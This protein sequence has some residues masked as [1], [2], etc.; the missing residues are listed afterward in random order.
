[1]EHTSPLPLDETLEAITAQVWDAVRHLPRLRDHLYNDDDS[2]PVF[3]AAT[4]EDVVRFREHAVPGLERPVEEAVTEAQDIF[5]F[6][7]HVNHPRF[8]S[9]IPS[10]ASPLSWLGDLLTSAF[11]TYSGVWQGGPGITTVEVTLVAWLAAQVGLPPSASGLF[12]SGG[13]MANLTAMA[14]ARDQRLRDDERTRG[15]AYFSDQTHF[16]VPKVLRIL[17]LFDGQMRTIPSDAKFRIDMVELEKAIITDKDQ[18][19]I[20]FLIVANCGTTNTGAI[21][22]LNEIADLAH[23]HGMWM[24]VDGAYGASVALSNSYRS[25]LSGLERADSLAWDAHKWLFQTFGCAIVLVRD[26]VHLA[27]SFTTSA[28]YLRDITT[29]DDTPNLFNYGI[30]LTRPARHMRLWFSLRVLGLDTFGRMIDHGFMLAATA[31]AELRKLPGW[32]ITSPATLSIVT[33]RYCPEGMA[34]DAADQFNAAI[35]SNAMQSNIAFIYTTRLRGRV[36]LRIC[37]INPQTS[38][39]DMQQIIKE[40]HNIACKHILEQ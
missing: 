15:V 33:F 32:K 26:K 31:E 1:M 30:E 21:D 10:P 23:V 6:R 27:Q 11:N 18:G 17:G 29:G 34:H 37:S 7:A 16:C 36:N 13:S 20:P 25:L 3:L 5:A 24:H 14:I 39:S 9:A 35:S 28:E 19:L 40:L 2:T 38:R 4:E 22:P 8:L 12:V